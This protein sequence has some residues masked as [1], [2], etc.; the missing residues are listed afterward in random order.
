MVLLLYSSPYFLKGH[1][2]VKK[3]ESGET[4]AFLLDSTTKGR[5][6]RRHICG[7]GDT[8]HDTILV[9]KKTL[10][11]LLDVVIH[12]NCMHTDEYIA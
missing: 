11:M 10:Y 9:P 3:E 1:D 6:N 8:D 12:V 2:I 7:M 5:S 4:Y